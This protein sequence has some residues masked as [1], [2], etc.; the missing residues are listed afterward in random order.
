MTGI[1]GNFLQH[2]TEKKHFR[3]IS[4]LF[5][6][7]LIFILI[8]SQSIFAGLQLDAGFHSSLTKA[9]AE[10]FVS[11]NLSDGKI[12]VGGY[13]SLANEVA[14]SNLARLNADGSTDSTFNSGG[15]GANG[16]IFDIAVQP[17]GK[18]LI[19]GSFKS[20]NGTVRNAVA[21]LNSDGTL[22]SSFSS[23][24][25][26]VN[27]SVKK[28]ALLGGGKILITGNMPG[29]I[30]RLNADG[31]PDTSF[32]SPFTF[33]TG[34]E[35]IA[36][37]SN[38][39][40][41]L[42]GGFFNSV[43]SLKQDGGIDD[44][45]NP[46]DAFGDGY[47]V[48]VLP[49][50]S[51]LV[52]G[53][54]FLDI[55]NPI[56]PSVRKFLPDGTR[57]QN[58][59]PPAFTFYNQTKSVAVLPDGKILIAGI[60]INSQ[61][62]ILS[63][64]KLNANGT[65]DSTFSIPTGNDQTRQVSFQ[66]DGK[67]LLFGSF[68]RI[69]NQSRTAI[70]RLNSEGTIDNT[71]DATFF[72]NTFVYD[73]ESQADGKI[74]AGGSFNFA[75][76]TAKS[77]TARF[78]PN[79]TLD[80]SFAVASGLIAD[81]ITCCKLIYDTEIQPDGKILLAGIFS[82]Y[83]GHLSRGMVRLNP[84]GT[85][86]T[87]FQTRFISSRNL[88]F[89]D[90]QLLPDGKI[91]ASIQ[92]QDYE[93]TFGFYG[94]VRLNADG[95]LDNSIGGSGII[96]KIARQADGK[97]LI[98]GLHID[99]IGGNR[100]LKRLNPDGSTDTTFNIGSGFNSTVL[101][102]L[103][104]PDGKILVAGTFTEFNGTPINRVA[105]LNPDGSLDSSFNPGS[106][107]NATVWEL[108]LLPDG[109]IA[110]GGNFS[111]FNGTNDNLLAILNPDGTSDPSFVSGF[112]DDPVNTVRSLLVQSDGKLIVGGH[113]NSYNGQPHENIVRLSVTN[114]K[115]PFD[116]DGDGKT[117]IS[118]FRPSVGEWWYHRS[119][120]NQVPAFQFG[121]ETDKI[122]PADYTGDGRADIAVWR[123]TTG[124]WFV[125]RSEDN[126]FYAFAFGANGDIPAPADYDGDG[127]A[128][129]AV[130]RP[131]NG[132]WYINRST[133]GVKIEPFGLSGD[134]PVPADY[135]GDG[136]ADIAVF[137]PS[138]GNWWLK[139]SSAGLVAANFGNGNDKPAAGDY[140][141]DGKADIAFW[142][143][144]TGEWF[145]LRSENASYYAA[146]FG[147]EGDI[148]T[149]GDYDGDGRIDTAVFRPSNSVWYVNRSTA[150]ILF[151]QFGLSTDKPVPSAFVP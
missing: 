39:R 65:L 108:A 123:E 31:T 55:E 120:D 54:Y 51:I 52:G 100:R 91:L 132:T 63:V 64:L 43:I 49:D 122:V 129:A 135:D 6:P 141:G 86:D 114:R 124:E 137:R 19:G 45:F 41:Y 72:A 131:A 118:I 93:G 126:S 66:N 130:F 34:A 94:L 89:L 113:F 11:K 81:P 148:P 3:V 117:D 71:F 147:M 62:D 146:Q 57:V 14:V 2:S 112:T 29:S 96:Y 105:R 27:N 144:S 85:P 77:D 15:S 60:L 150:G 22:D 37:D 4:N 101:D 61:P 140:T 110:V 125:L 80:S 74:I 68:S 56:Q 46:T 59:F 95:S 134:V 18:I 97:I 42:A 5:L 119:S 53:E 84:D 8:N 25:T 12:L 13:F 104:Q 103:V 149:A 70:V 36:I 67:I 128:D 44:K 102:I 21:R 26:A 38:D 30:K 121:A 83:N 127:K 10:I 143:P 151:Q 48:E 33:T 87:T 109:K 99:D 88:W 23:P 16:S 35:D 20:Y 92:A 145:V 78:N 136:S 139:R 75:H 79:G 69:N 47:D 111:V 32:V 142:R 50:N 40:I 7:V 116:F 90:I 28:I 76:G 1:S 115:T 133:G 24:L 9:T 17:D 106:G 138:D 58:F 82:G 107:A 98:G 73:L